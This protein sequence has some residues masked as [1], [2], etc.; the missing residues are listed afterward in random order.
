MSDRRKPDIQHNSDSTDLLFM[1]ET[2]LFE[3]APDE[4]IVAEFDKL[5]KGASRDVINQALIGLLAQRPD[6]I[7]MLKVTE[8]IRKERGIEGR[9]SLARD[10]EEVIAREEVSDEEIA[11]LFN[12]NFVDNDKSNIDSSLVNIVLHRSHL[13]PKLDIDRNFIDAHR[14]QLPNNLNLA[15]EIGLMIKDGASDEEITTVLKTPGNRKGKFGVKNLL[16]HHHPRLA[17][18]Y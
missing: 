1:V 15:L 6:I 14:I 4:E 7:P 9:G 2:K 17:S 11:K 8:E 10:M 16:E 3:G 18:N 12:D 13:I 5:Y